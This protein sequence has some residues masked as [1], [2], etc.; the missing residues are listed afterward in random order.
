[1]LQLV[2]CGLIGLGALVWPGAAAAD[3]IAKISVEGT[4]LHVVL[5]SGKTLQAA[6]L[7]GAVLTLDLAGIGLSQVRIDQVAP[8]PTDPHGEILLYHFS[9]QDGPNGAWH[10][11]CDADPDGKKL[12]LLLAGQWD[13]AGQQ[14]SRQGLTL[15]CTSGVIAKCVRFGYKPWKVLP[16][17]TAL[18]PYHEACVHMVRA[19]YCG[20]DQPTTQAGMPIDIYDKLGIQ[21]PEVTNVLPFEA[22]WDQ[23]GAICVAHTR[24]P[25]NMSLQQLAKSCPRLATHLGAAVCNGDS[26]GIIGQPLLFN[27]S[28]TQPP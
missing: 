25:Q 9:L 15:A 3:T 8:D 11:A 19:D 26:A 28:A 7:V 10:D 2:I 17:G 23:N 14:S 5:Q 24:V 20:T 21:T 1:M 4:A 18:R 12:A 6:D 27:R 16:D 13:H 22:A